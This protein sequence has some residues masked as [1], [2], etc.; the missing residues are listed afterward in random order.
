MLI[1]I[2]D[3][4][5]TVADTKDR[6][7]ALIKKHDLSIELWK[8]E[9]IAEFTKSAY[10]KNDPIIPGAEILPFLARICGAKLVFLTGR[11]DRARDATR[12]WL[13]YRLNI[14]D[15]VPLIMRKDGDLSNPVEC[16]LNLFKDTVLKMYPDGNFIFF[17]DDEILLAEYSK[18]GL[19]LR[20]PECWKT[21][22]F[23]GDINE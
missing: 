5:N 8:E 11:S 6:I 18:Y 12:V 22:K 23:V 10:L 16:K 19:A 21:I 20:A 17:D 7:D 13:E 3:I 14:F 9:A 2:S 4:D 1:L 15:S